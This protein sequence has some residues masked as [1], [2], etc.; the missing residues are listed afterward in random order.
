MCSSA[1]LCQSVVLLLSLSGVCLWKNS[2]QL[3]KTPPNSHW[4]RREQQLL[5]MVEH[6]NSIQ[7]MLA[8][9]EIAI[10]GQLRP[11]VGAKVLRILP[12]LVKKGQ[13]SGPRLID[14][15]SSSHSPAIVPEVITALRKTDLLNDA[16]L[17]FL[18]LAILARRGLQAKDAIPVL[19][20]NLEEL[21]DPYLRAY[22]RVILA[23]LGHN[24]KALLNDIREDLR[25]DESRHGFLSAM[26]MVDVSTQQWITEDIIQTITTQMVRDNDW[27]Q[28]SL[29][30]LVLGLLGER[31]RSSKANLLK[32]QHRALAEQP[33]SAFTIGL[34][35]ARVDHKNRRNT[36]ATLIRTFPRI[37]EQ[38]GHTTVFVLLTDSRILLDNSLRHE[39]L[40]L[41]GHSD[42]E[43]AD[44]AT[45][46]LMWAGPTATTN[47]CHLLNTVRKYANS[48]RLPYYQSVLRR[49]STYSH[50]PT[51]EKELRVE[52]DGKMKAVILTV[53][54]SVREFGGFGDRLYLPRS[55]DS[56]A[57]PSSTDRN[58]KKLPEQDKGG[59]RIFR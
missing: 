39:L 57:T 27:H 51:L 8:L 53:I 30:A 55:M 18:Y 17:R 41:L 25:H 11:Q 45:A 13:V 56:S 10:V 26:A 23:C 49:F 40:A 59:R 16:E 44:G 37:S 2:N 43:L 12:D 3:D 42:S 34:A 19:K 14:A 33:I 58:K 54:N 50:L 24:S 1:C 36:L 9:E 22:L 31:A 28:R 52:R 48:E 15:I 6:G 4:T 21:S 38:F 5:R 7:S 46:L 35:V 47:H 32:L 20:S 29:A